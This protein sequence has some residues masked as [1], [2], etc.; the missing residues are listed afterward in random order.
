[1]KKIILINSSLDN[2]NKKMLDKEDSISS[3]GLGYIAHQL[4]KSCRKCDLYKNQRP[5]L[6]E[7]FKETDVM[8]LGISAVKIKNENMGYPLA[9]DT[10]TG[11]IVEEIEKLAEKEVW[12]SNLVKCLPLDK[13]YKIRAPKKLE[14]EACYE[15]YV[16]EIKIRNPKLVVLLGKDVSNFILKKETV[17]PKLDENFEYEYIQKDGIK[18]LAVHHPSYILKMKIDI[19]ER[20]KTII[21][22][23]MNLSPS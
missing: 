12:K 18:Y 15:N 9:K 6:D 8:F 14:M 19:R 4:E 2:M 22:N 3:V 7:S 17:L 13:N 21:A 5:I 23:L 1:M 20:Y 16:Y 11:K 10:R